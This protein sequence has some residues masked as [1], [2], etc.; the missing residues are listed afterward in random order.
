[1]PEQGG[2][3]SDIHAF[4]D[5]AIWNRTWGEWFRGLLPGGKKPEAPKPSGREW[6]AP[7]D[8][9]P[10]VS[11][12]IDELGYDDDNGIMEVEFHDGAVFRYDVPHERDFDDLVEAPSIGQKFYYD[13]RTSV[14]YKKVKDKD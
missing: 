8:R 4:N 11:S 13:F 10:V 5:A 1:L 6:T 9:E 7:I 12:Y 14:P 3:V 2:V